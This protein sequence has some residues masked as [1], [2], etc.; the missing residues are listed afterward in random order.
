M[1]FGKVGYWR[2]RFLQLQEKGEAVEEW[3]AD[4]DAIESHILPLVS[5][6]SATL[7]VGCG[8][9]DLHFAF[10]TATGGGLHHC[11]DY[12]WSVLPSNAE[13]GR[14]LARSSPLPFQLEWMQA[15]AR[16]LPLRSGVY[17]LV[18]DKGLIDQFFILEDEGLETGMAHL[19]SELAR[20]LRR[21]GHYAFVTIGNKYDRLY[22]LKKVGVWE[23]KIEVVELRPSTNTL[24]AS[25]LF[26]VTKK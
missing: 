10:A 17:D 23:E 25:Y 24:G 5:K 2:E 12:I 21:G 13:K 8:L 11:L 7:H 19:Q 3:C 20:V 18:L 15:D 9:S 26:V 22:S 4:F 1:E 6:H 14:Q 16:S